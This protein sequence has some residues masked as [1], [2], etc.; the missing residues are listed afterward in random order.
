MNK[1]WFPYAILGVLIL[2][3]VGRALAPGRLFVPTDLLVERWPPW[4]E[5]NV[6]VEVHNIMLTDV[7]NYIYPVKTFAAE[8]VRHGEW[9][10]WNPYIFTGYP[11]TYNTQAGLFYPLTLF[12]ILFDGAT[13]VDLTIIS[14]LFLG[15]LFMSLYLRQLGLH[16][17]AVLLGGVL[18]LFNGHMIVWLE[19]QVV[20]A[21][22]IWLPAQLYLVEKIGHRPKIGAHHAALALLFA[23]PWLGGH[24]NWTLYTSMTVAVYMLWRLPH[25]RNVRHTLVAL[26]LGTAVAMIQVIPAFNYLRQTHRQPLPFAELLEYGLWSRAVAFFVP[27]FFGNSVAQ[28]WWGPAISN[29]VETAVYL[30]LLAP[31]LAGGALFMRRDWHTRFFAAWGAI[32]LLWALGTRAYG[33]LYL[34]PVFDGLHPSRASFAALF[35]L[36]MLAVLG[37]DALLRGQ[38]VGLSASLGAGAMGLFMPLLVAGFAWHHQSRLDDFLRGELLIFGAFWLASGLLIAM[39]HRHKTGWLGGLMV[40]CA[41][42]DLWWFGWDFNTIGYTADLYPSTET[43]VYLQAD[44]ERELSRMVSVADGVA[45]YPNTSLAERI[46][47]FSGYEPGIPLRQVN[48]LR[49]AEAGEPIHFERILMPAQDGGS[50]LLGALNVKHI[51]TIRERW[52]AEPVALE[53]INTAWADAP[54]ERPL[55]VPFGGLQ[56]LD[57]AVRGQADGVLTVRVLS[58][59]GG[60]EFANAQVNTADIANGWASFFFAPFPSAWGDAFLVR[61]DAPAGMEVG[62][63]VPFY[64]PRPALVHE[65]RKTRIYE[66]EHWLPRAYAVGEAVIVPDEAAAL[67]RLSAVQN[68]L[69]KLVVLE[70]EGNPSPPN[71]ARGAIGTAEISQY[72]LNEIHLQANLDRAGFV[73][74]SDSYDAGWQAWANG[75]QLPVY[76]ANSV[77][78]AVWLPAGVHEV[79]WVYRPWDF[80]LGVAISGAALLICL[81]CAVQYNHRE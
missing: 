22:V 73:V 43:A 42:V 34:L 64:L 60:Y 18:F 58:A 52:G 6:P 16:P 77:G 70:L 20:H 66:N 29:D 33:V 74:L 40:L 47:N 23:V 44:L 28:N 59:D 56:R 10:L 55:D 48:Y 15:G 31:L 65:S 41:V 81:G 5:P 11:F 19:W 24:W 76:R 51:V 30:G 25:W 14:Q 80:W 36:I 45:F 69:D 38:K 68:E 1:T 46:P 62:E 57:A 75:E 9:P 8:A 4:Q 3:F 35:A 13:A 71:G 27:N 2:L 78:R 7:V 79:H 26:G 63:M 39:T 32:T 21:A 17:W 53:A 49:T 54:L 67:A 37:A 50:P 72:G 61:L 12:Y